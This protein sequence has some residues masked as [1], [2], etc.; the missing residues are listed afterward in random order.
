MKLRH[1][2]VLSV[3][4]STAP[5]SFAGEQRIPI[6]AFFD[7]PHLSGAKLSPDGKRLAMLVKNDQGRDQLGVVNLEDESMKVVAVFSDMDVGRFEW[8]NKGRLLYNSRDKRT[9]QGDVD[10]AP[11]LFAVNIDGSGQRQLAHMGQ[12]PPS[13]TARKRLPA[14]T[15]MLGQPGAQDSDWVYVLS[16]DFSSERVDLIRVN[17]VSGFSKE[18]KGPGSTRRWWF[19][20][21]GE[22]ALATTIENGMELLYYLDPTNGSWRELGSMANMGFADIDSA[23][24]PAAASDD[25]IDKVVVSARAATLKFT[26]LGFTPEGE[27]YVI[28]H[29]KRDKDA[30]FAYDLVTGKLAERPLLDLGEYDFHGT[31]VTS[32]TRLLGV[33]YTVDAESTR[34]FDPAMKQM[35]DAVDQLLP[36]RVN[37]LSVGARSETPF[38]LVESWSDREPPV[39]LLFN[40][41]TGQLS[42]VGKSRPAIAPGQM[43][44]QVLEQVKAR[45]GLPIPTW[46]TIPNH[47]QGKKLPMVVLVHGGPWTRGQ[48]WGWSSERQFLASRGYIVLEPEFRGSTGFGQAHFQAGWKQW[49]L[50]MQDDIADVTRWAIAENIADPR[51]ICIAGGGYGGYAALMGLI[52]DP[53]LYRCGIAWAGV[54]DLDLLYKGHAIGGSDLSDEYKRYG[55]PALVGDPV[56]DAARFAASSPL[57]HATRIV[58]PLLLAYG[59]DDRRVP[60]SHGRQLYEAVRQTNKNVEWIVYDKEGNGGGLVDGRDGLRAP[61]YQG[62]TVYDPVRQTNQ[63]VEWVVYQKQGRTYNEYTDVPAYESVDLMTVYEKEGHGWGLARTRVDFWG[64]VEKFLQQHIGDGTK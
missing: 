61:V 41:E 56:K 33:R 4:L 51:R 15:L 64:R 46:I 27:L 30:L 23:S 47:S 57:K 19:D 44:E 21:K 55:F 50:S 53:A 5:A 43:A 39:F 37:T 45:D 16:P 11:G 38:V 36:G 6:A 28:S 12:L 35:Q 29:K 10:K 63:N 13:P 14:N 3:A 58:Q 22:P 8:V 17:T 60:L 24:V 18:V 48:E 42:N 20:T 52:R 9:A 1:A 31:L 59:D 49:G 32:A 25:K 2:L 62:G 34:W 7:S 54:T 26:P 40:R